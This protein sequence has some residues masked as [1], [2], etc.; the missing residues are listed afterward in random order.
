M[1]CKTE[2]TQNGFTLVETIVAILILVLTIGALLTLTAGGF[3]TIRY[4]KNDIVAG[5]LVQESLEYIRST[6]DTMAQAGGSWEEW[7]RTYTDAG[8][9]SKDGC[10]INPYAS[11]PENRVMACSG[12]CPFMIFFPGSNFYAYNVDNIFGSSIDQPYETSFIRTIRMEVIDQQT[13]DS[14]PSVAVT[15]TIQ[16][17]NGTNR[18]STTQSGILTPWNF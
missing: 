16:W 8:C 15:A 14:A 4:V 17:M 6:R 13:S 2:T 1:I 9:M 12:D 10:S 5:N 7:Y 18:K 3:F 11:K